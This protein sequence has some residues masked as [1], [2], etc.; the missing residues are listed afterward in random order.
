MSPDGNVLCEK[1]KSVGFCLK[2]LNIYEV[3]EWEWPE[4]LNQANYATFANLIP[5]RPEGWGYGTYCKRH[6]QLAFDAFHQED[7]ETAY[8]HFGTVAQA[9]QH[10]GFACMGMALCTFQLQ[11][12]NAAQE[13][14]QDDNTGASIQPQQSEYNAEAGNREK[15][16]TKG[17]KLKRFA[18][19]K[20]SVV[21]S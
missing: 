14:A 1:C 10:S 6:L 7:F 3:R 8:L 17:R 12:A 11:R 18:E 13:K 2:Y 19:R 4:I 16:P 21:M 15:A 20:N 9:A 5:I